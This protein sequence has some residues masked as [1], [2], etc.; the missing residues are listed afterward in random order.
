MNKWTQQHI[1]KWNAFLKSQGLSDEEAAKYSMWLGVQ[2]S[3]E[4][5]YG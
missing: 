1:A 4:T 3:F 5:G 2:D